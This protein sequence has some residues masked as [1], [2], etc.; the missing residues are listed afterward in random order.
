MEADGISGGVLLGAQMA[1]PV[2]EKFVINPFFI[3][4]MGI[5]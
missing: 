3:F 4:F 2:F 5:Y 1:I